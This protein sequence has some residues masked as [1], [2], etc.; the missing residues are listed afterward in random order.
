MLFFLKLQ[1]A[2]NHSSNPKDATPE[3][4]FNAAANQQ[5]QAERQTIVSTQLIW[6]AHN[7]TPCTQCMQGV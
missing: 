6:S 5:S 1:K 3:R 7:N 4:R 2:E